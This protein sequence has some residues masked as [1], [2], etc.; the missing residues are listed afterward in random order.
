MKQTMIVHWPMEAKCLL[1][2]VIRIFV[3]NN[4]AKIAVVKIIRITNSEDLLHTMNWTTKN[5]YGDFSIIDSWMIDNAHMS[6]K[7]SFIVCGQK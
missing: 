7:M 3:V 2:L 4:L 5:H 6:M 1:L